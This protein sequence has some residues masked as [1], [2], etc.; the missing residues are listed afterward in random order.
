MYTWFGNFYATFRLSKVLG[1]MYAFW[2]GDWS[3]VLIEL[4][5]GDVT[6]IPAFYWC[7]GLPE[8]T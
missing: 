1:Y 2:E 4:S 8:L 3:M 7:I 5:T 6:I